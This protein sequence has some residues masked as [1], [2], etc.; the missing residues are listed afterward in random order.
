MSE[1]AS[2]ELALRRFT[3]ETV[4]GDL[5][6]LTNEIARDGHRALVQMTPAQSGETKGN[7][8]LTVG[9]P[10]S[11]SKGAPDPSGSRVLQ[12]GEAAL[13]ERTDPF[14]PVWLNATG[15]KF[16]WLNNGT[17]KMAGRHMIELTIER[18]KQKFGR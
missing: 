7:I 15:F 10:T 12:E 2:F 6:E 17:R 11:F 8:H 18:L 16:R 1:L 5:L 13:A 4:P 14:S 9:S 3:E